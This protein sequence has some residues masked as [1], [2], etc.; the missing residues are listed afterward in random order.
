MVPKQKNE[1]EEKRSIIWEWKNKP[2]WNTKIVQH[3]GRM[4]NL[5][6]IINI[7]GGIFIR[8]ISI[9][10]NEDVE[11]FGDSLYFIKLYYIGIYIYRTNLNSIATK[12]MKLIRQLV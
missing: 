11:L 8:Y 5:W 2:Q 3:G 4:S 12:I 7:L 10:Y 6:D 9:L 1:T